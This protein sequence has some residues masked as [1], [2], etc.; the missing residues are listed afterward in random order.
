MK[1]VSKIVDTKKANQDCRPYDWLKVLN[2]YAKDKRKFSTL[3]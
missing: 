1:I 3:T 2:R